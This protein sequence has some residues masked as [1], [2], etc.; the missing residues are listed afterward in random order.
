MPDP[1]FCWICGQQHWTGT[2]M[3]SQCQHNA[4]SI[5]AS[6]GAK[7][8][9]D[10]AK[11]IHQMSVAL[12]QVA[13][14][15]CAHCA[16]GTSHP[17]WVGTT[18]TPA[19]RVPQRSR[20]A[21]GRPVSKEQ[22]ARAIE[23]LKLKA[24]DESATRIRLAQE[25]H[26]RKLKIKADAEAAQQQHL[27]DLEALRQERAAEEAEIERQRRWQKEVASRQ[28]VGTWVVTQNQNGGIPMGWS[29]P[30]WD[31]RTGEWA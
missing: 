8:P 3:C 5:T 31:G 16:K 11:S 1:A 17:T 24:A 13:E 2:N 10:V 20:R 18:K 25:A 4:L 15:E 26:A 22:N 27:R 23:L 28:E 7:M 9:A 21:T 6:T 29:R 30:M 19:T 12:N 14:T